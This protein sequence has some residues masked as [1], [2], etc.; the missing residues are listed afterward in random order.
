M[1]Q[2]NEF[3]SQDEV[4]ALLNGIG[5]DGT[6]GNLRQAPQGDVR[7]Y[8]PTSRDH[9]SETRLPVLE[10]INEKFS[11]ALRIALS[12]FT[13]LN[14]DLTLS[15]IRIMK[16]A[17]LMH[18]IPAITGISLFRLAP[19]S[20]NGALFLDHSTTAVI[21]DSLFG[22]EGRA[23]REH[24]SREFTPIEVRM[25]EKVNGLTLE[26]FRKSW[27]H[28][29]PAEFSYLRSETHKQFIRLCAADDLVIVTSINVKVGQ[30]GGE[31]ILCL[32]YAALEPVRHLLAK[33]SEEEKASADRN[34]F[35]LLT[36]Q[37]QSAEV[38][39]NA[40]LGTAI[41][42]LRQIMEMKPGDFIPV[43]VPDTVSAM[44][45]GLPLMECHFGVSNGQYS[46]RVERIV[47]H[48]QQETSYG[49]HGGN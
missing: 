20:G 4:D 40:N 14:C 47:P 36:A 48:N 44:V 13:K 12:E 42:P 33:A 43:N 24:V 18:G 22:G 37:V 41:I 25:V 11:R 7:P 1:D 5:Q 23:P 15:P 9:L 30:A 38:E 16:H 21:I 49:S 17:E 35:R 28:V 29:Y 8:D 34:W 46:L 39:L 19:L 10:N 31:I 2:E 6:A 3:L 32:P 45:D 27:A 26:C